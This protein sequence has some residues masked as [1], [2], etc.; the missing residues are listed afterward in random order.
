MQTTL[1]DLTNNQ[2]SATDNL[3]VSISFGSF[4]TYLQQRIQE[5]DGMK[6]EFFEYAFS[7]LNTDKAVSGRIDLNDIQKH[8]EALYLIYNLLVPAIAE[9]TQQL[10]ALGVPLKPH[11][12]FGTNS[13]YNLIQNFDTGAVKC[14]ILNNTNNDMNNKMKVQLLCSLILE[15]LY[16]F[17]PLHKNEFSYVVVNEQT[18]LSNYF[19]IH[20]DTRFV[21]VESKEPLPDLDLLKIAAEM[22]TSDFEWETLCSRLP[23]TSLHFSGFSIITAKDITGPQAIENIKSA[24]INRHPGDD[25]DYYK[26]VVNSLKTIVESNAIEFGLLPVFMVN[27]KL[28]VTKENKMHN[29]MVNAFTTK[30]HQD[31]F[32]KR[33]E[34]YL[35]NPGVIL[36]SDITDDKDANKYLL[37]LHKNGITSYALFPV[38]SGNRVVGVLEIYSKKEHILTPATLAKLEP[39]LPLLSQLF[40][41]HIDE[42]GRNIE[43][44]IKDK[45]TSLQPAVEWKF[46][47]IAWHYYNNNEGTGKKK[48]EEKIVFRDVFPLYGAIDIRNSTIERNNAQSADLIAQFKLIVITLT[49][50]KKQVNITLADELIFKCNSWLKAIETKNINEDNLKITEFFDDEIHPF[51]DYFK[52]NNPVLEPIIKKYRDAINEETGIVYYNRR[53]LEKSMQTINGAINQYLEFFRDEVQVAYPCYFEKFRTDGIEYDIYIGQSISPHKPFNSL[54]LKNIRLWQLKS[55]VAIAKIT[56]GLQP[57]LEK[58]LETTQLI[59]IRST[60]IDIGFRNDERRFDV[61][62]S[63]NIR[64]Q[65]IKKRIDKVHVKLTGERLTQPDKIALVYF[66]KKE[67]DEY[68][69]YIKYLQSK[70][71]LKKDIEFLELEELQGVT[72]LKAIRVSIVIDHT[73]DTEKQIISAMLEK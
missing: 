59:F 25:G 44:I 29:L 71:M 60:A 17:P 55:M 2:K 4:L 23:L 66:N 16:N 20:I 6:K 30:E 73:E 26:G 39:A 8:K 64:Y 72:G 61:E 11:I 45:F 57:Q 9:E 27:N 41:H 36:Y 5:E 56:H 46:R 48:L 49:E 43:N 50:I 31:E 51:L 13:F 53:V 35:D 70:N 32:Y 58:K 24:I 68:L 21:K 15:K 54:Y 3:D 19:K 65:V 22:E 42:F 67:A 34:A 52:D 62:G 38:Y 12:F 47:D 1:L 28:V 10:W 7:K 37:Y 69:E 33:T 14:E 40:Q 18:G 63:Y